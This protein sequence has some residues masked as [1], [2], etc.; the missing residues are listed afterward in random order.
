MRGTDL[1]EFIAGAFCDQLMFPRGANRGSSSIAE[2]V[3]EVA[4]QQ[5]DPRENFVEARTV[6]L[7]RQ[8]YFGGSN[9][10]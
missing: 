4:L 1:R 7:R 8:P 3:L 2:G 9:Q 5:T 6:C 10:S